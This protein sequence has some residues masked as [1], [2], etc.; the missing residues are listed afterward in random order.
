M[1]MYIMMINNTWIFFFYF[2]WGQGG[3]YVIACPECI[4]NGYHSSMHHFS[5]IDV[6]CISITAGT[7]I[8][9]ILL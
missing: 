9:S 7:G 6:C 3:W 2:E 1:Y 4:L 8:G 5:S